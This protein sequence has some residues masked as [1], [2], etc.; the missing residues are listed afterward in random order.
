MGFTKSSIIKHIPPENKR[1][2]FIARNWG[3]LL[4]VERTVTP[5]GNTRTNIRI[6][7][8]SIINTTRWGFFNSNYY[9]RE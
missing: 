4:I 3:F 8:I 9:S 2:V 7:N 1:L 6:R 5:R